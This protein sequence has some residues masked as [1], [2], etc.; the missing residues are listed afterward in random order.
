MNG[1]RTL[2][3]YR[4][5]DL[6]MFAVMLMVFEPLLVAAGTKW[7]PGEPYTVSVT[8]V[9]TCIV[10]MRWGPWAGLHAALGG[11]VYCLASEAR[12]M[13]YAI[14]CVGNLLSLLSLGLIRAWSAE[15]IRGSVVKS[16]LMAVSVTVLMQ[17]G[18]AL[19]SLLFGTAPLTAMGFLTTDVIT[20]LFTVVL[21]WIARRL[22]GLFEEQRHYLMRIQSK[23]EEERGGY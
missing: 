10:M 6:S 13:H 15:G 21:I 16:L 11:F 12:P 2:G 19:V 9:V 17:L 22:D 18:R 23:E 1:K 20:L 4:A 5:V 3:Q 7:F 14:Y 8:P